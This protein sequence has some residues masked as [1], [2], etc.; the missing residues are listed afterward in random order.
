MITITLSRYLYNILVD[1]VE[2]KYKRC[3]GF[4]ECINCHMYDSC[5]LLQ[6]YKQLKRF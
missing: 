2:E 1:I 6:L 4:D 3:K 5:N